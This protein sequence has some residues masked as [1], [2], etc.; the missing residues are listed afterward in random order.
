MVATELTSDALIADLMTKQEYF[1]VYDEVYK[2]F[3][4]TD[5]ILDIV[6]QSL[7]SQDLLLDFDAI[8]PFD[9][10]NPD[11][12]A[13][14][15]LH[16][17]NNDYTFTRLMKTYA[18]PNAKYRQYYIYTGTPTGNFQGAKWE[19]LLVMLS[20]MLVLGIRILI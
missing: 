20:Y 4:S 18:E 19:I 8:G 17:D 12:V 7:I 10:S 6:S 9:N 14:L 11:N 1:A 13:D 16:Q 15:K 2:I 5:M 3:H